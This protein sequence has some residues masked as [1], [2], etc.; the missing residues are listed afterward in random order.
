M[1]ISTATKKMIAA[2][3]DIAQPTMFFTGFFRTPV[4]NFYNSEKVALD[5]IRTSEKVSVAIRHF[6]E[7][8]RMNA[9][10]IYT[11]KEFTA[12]VHQEAIPIDSEQLIKRMPGDNP[13]KDPGYR[14]A[15]ITMLMN[16]MVKVSDLIF[17]AIELQ[18]SQV[19]Q[20]GIVTLKDENDDSIYDIDYKPKATH[21]PTSGTTWGQV[22][23]D[24]LGD[25]ASLAD[26]IRTDGKHD[27]DLVIMGI[28]AFEAFIKDTDVKARL[29]NRRIDMGG[30]VRR[31]PAGNGASFRGVID[32]GHYSYEIWTYSGQYED[33]VTGNATQYLDKGKVVVMA[34]DGR[35]DGTYGNIPNI[36]RILGNQRN[37]LVPELPRRLNSINGMFDLHPNLW[38]EPSG[39]TLNAGVGSRPLM[40]PTAIDTY[41]CLDTGL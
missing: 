35:L 13:F 38:I 30:I 12:P 1:T 15:V 11:T 28:D 10:N 36:G 23:A 25:I 8:Y 27:P 9:A 16:G 7:G 37:D 3:S 18:A 2:Y 17:R 41:G 29:D 6:S 24:P 14:A 20:T 5:I 4:Q 26:V 39:Q 33:P 22:G 31:R 34:S 32:I 19:M 21:F 40:I